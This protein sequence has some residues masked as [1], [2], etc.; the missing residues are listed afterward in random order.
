MQK[1]NETIKQIQPLKTAFISKAQERLDRLTKP[2]GS[3]GI[4]EKFA[5]RIVAITENMTPTFEKKTVIV[6]AGDHGVADEG[7]SAYPKEVTVQMVY[8]FLQGGAAINVLARYVNAKV[9]V[10]DMGI[11]GDIEEHPGLISNNSDTAPIASTAV[12]P[13]QENRQFKR[14]KPGLKSLNPNMLRTALM[15]WY[16]VIWA[17]ETQPRAVQSSRT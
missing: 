7:V 5:A 4:L 11:A 8:N 15:F 9:L 3:L 10:V 6:M 2:Q 1:I 13:C 17:S 14:F 16:L 12:L